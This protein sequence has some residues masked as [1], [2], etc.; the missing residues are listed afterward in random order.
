MDA[1]DARA[2]SRRLASRRILDA[3]LSRDLRERNETKRNEIEDDRRRGYAA[4][5]LI[6]RGERIVFQGRSA[7]S[8]SV[9]LH[10]VPFAT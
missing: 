5:W 8:R 2:A 6:A 3:T 9:P 10:S 4:R 7:R 1:A